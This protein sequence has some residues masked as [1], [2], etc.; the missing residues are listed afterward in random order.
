MTHE[1]QSRTGEREKE[2]VYVRAYILASGR[3]RNQLA[4]KE[5]RD[6]GTSFKINPVLWTECNVKMWNVNKPSVQMYAFETGVE[7]FS[8]LSF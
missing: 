6:T 1:G 8:S 4:A 2:T 5:A 3:N 7:Y